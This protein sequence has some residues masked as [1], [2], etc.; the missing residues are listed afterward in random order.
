M[1][2]FS[3]NSLE[4]TELTVNV[5]DNVALTCQADGRPT[6][7]MTLIRP[8]GDV[9]ANVPQGTPSIA[10]EIKEVTGEVTVQCR[11]TGVYHC[12]VNNGVGSTQRR[13]VTIFVQCKFDRRTILITSLTIINLKGLKQIFGNKIAPDRF[14]TTYRSVQTF[15]EKKQSISH[16]FKTFSGLD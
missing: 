16:L 10:D 6:P 14:E 13:N 3:L 9:I 15:E 2:S 11:D 8:S 5:S 4:T 7:K 12:D 1:L